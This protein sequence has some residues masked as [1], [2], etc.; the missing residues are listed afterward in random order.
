MASVMASVSL[1][2]F[3]PVPVMTVVGY[4]VVSDAAAPAA[5]S[6]SPPSTRKGGVGNAENKQQGQEY[7]QGFLERLFIFSY[8]LELLHGY[9]PLNK[10]I[11]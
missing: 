10:S 4:A 8:K 5:R 3:I 7:D 6:S 9:F 1:A 2:L 11:T